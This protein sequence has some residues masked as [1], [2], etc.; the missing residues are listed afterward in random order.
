[1]GHQNC[2][3]PP[4]VAP[5]NHSC[6]SPSFCPSE[7]LILQA[8]RAAQ[9]MRTLYLRR[10][11]C[12]AHTQHP[13]YAFT[14]KTMRKPRA[15]ATDPLFSRHAELSPWPTEPPPAQAKRPLYVRSRPRCSVQAHHNRAH[16]AASVPSAPPAAATRFFTRGIAS[17]TSNA[18]HPFGCVRSLAR[19]RY[20]ANPRPSSKPLAQIPCQT[21]QNARE[22]SIRPL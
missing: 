7:Q 18:A 20:L 13:H 16:Q 19:P 17:L 1:M 11:I 10:T 6:S 4:R 5:R 14:A 9:T 2:A 22:K 15:G 3:G 8:P 21:V 12:T